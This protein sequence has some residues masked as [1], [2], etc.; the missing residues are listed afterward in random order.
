MAD[1]A[2]PAIDRQLHDIHGEQLAELAGIF[3]PGLVA[4]VIGLR[5][6]PDRGQEL[7]AADDLV[8]HR[9]HMM[10]PAAGAEKVEV[11]LAGR[12]ARQRRHQVALQLDFGFELA[13]QAERRLQPMR[14]GDL[15]EQ[16]VDAGR[17]DLRQH[18]LLEAGDG[19]RHPGMGRGFV[20]C[21]G[22]AP[23][24]PDAG[25]GILASARARRNRVYSVSTGF[26]RQR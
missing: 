5:R 19:V 3:E 13:W 22:I 8:D 11:L 15:G 4:P 17:A 25:P 16:L 21:H 26:N 7:G 10:L 9:R 14:G 2:A 1:G 24:L 20:R 23:P 12:V 6:A 18:R